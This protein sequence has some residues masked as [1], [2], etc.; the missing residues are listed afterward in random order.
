MALFSKPAEVNDAPRLAAS[1]EVTPRQIEKDPEILSLVPPATRTY[2]V[3]LGTMAPQAWADL[4]KTV[5][6]AGL[7]P[8][9]HIA[10]RRLKS[11]DDLAERLSAMVDA[12]GVR[13]VLL[14]AGGAGDAAGPFESSMDVLETGLLD[15]HGIRRIGVAG[16]PEG[17]PDIA[18][19]L[20]AQA[21]DWKSAFA[22]RT[23]ADM[24]IVTQFGFDAGAAITWASH[25][26]DA[27]IGLPIHL[28]VAGPA[29]I[30]SLLKYAAMCGVR[31]SSA[32]AFKRGSAITSL[33]TSYSPEPFVQPIEAHVADHAETLIQQL[34]VFP[35]G[36]LSETSK[37]LSGR[38]TWAVDARAP[39]AGFNAPR[40]DVPAVQ[41]AN[42]NDG[43]VA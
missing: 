34:H 30:K 20:I 21:L 13:D 26:K 1:V 12:A 24:R 32:F 38:G 16:H 11:R 36:G 15:A 14:I 25:L 33:M 10:A 42:A 27:G 8:V 29:S 41:L 5:T 2:L 6:R 3:D 18:E 9:P 39:I 43:G 31:A 37:W 40:V 7:E 23:G 22:E 17:S 4:L 35:F 19:H 28:G